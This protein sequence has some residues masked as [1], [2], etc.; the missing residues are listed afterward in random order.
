MQV[1]THLLVLGWISIP[2]TEPVRNS[3]RLTGFQLKKRHQRNEVSDFEYTA[4]PQKVSSGQLPLDPGYMYDATL[5]EK[6]THTFD[7]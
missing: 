1:R 5:K 4:A 3:F 7:T 6:L 2:K